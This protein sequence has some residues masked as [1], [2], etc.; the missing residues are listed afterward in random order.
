MNYWEDFYGNRGKE[1]ANGAKAGMSLFAWWKDGVQYVGTTGRT[2]KEALQDVDDAYAVE[3][4]SD[5]AMKREAELVY[6]MMKIYGGSFEQSLASVLCLAD[7]DNMR[8]LKA[9]FPEFWKRNLI[10]AEKTAAK[11]ANRRGEPGA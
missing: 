2:L 7:V 1:F 11:E 5:E 9:A 4:L 10:L 3:A 6:R 8:S